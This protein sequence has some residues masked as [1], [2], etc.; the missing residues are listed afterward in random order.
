MGKSVEKLVDAIDESLNGISRLV[1]E[2]TEGYNKFDKNLIKFTVQQIFNHNKGRPAQEIID[3][4]NNSGLSSIMPIG[5][6][7]QLYNMLSVKMITSIKKGVLSTL[8]INIKTDKLVKEMQN[9]QCKTT[10]EKRGN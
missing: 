1:E 5:T 10:D 8:E 2:V 7:Q 6:G 3:A 4:V 9:I